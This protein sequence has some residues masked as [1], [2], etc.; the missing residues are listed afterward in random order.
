MANVFWLVVPDNYIE[1]K[2]TP[3]YTGST[4]PSTVYA[5]KAL[6][7]PAY[8]PTYHWSQ[9]LTYLES[10][11]FYRKCQELIPIKPMQEDFASFVQDY[12]SKRPT[13]P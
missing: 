7:A 2:A 4:M 8:P 3:T 5:A 9:P 10:H 1:N 11:S 13:F 12:W 6:Q